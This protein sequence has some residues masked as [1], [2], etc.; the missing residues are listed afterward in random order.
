MSIRT[1]VDKNACGLLNTSLIDKKNL[2][3]A[4]L[5][6]SHPAAVRSLEY[7]SGV[8]CWNDELKQHAHILLDSCTVPY[9]QSARS[10]LVV[11]DTKCYIDTQFFVDRAEVSEILEH[12]SQ[13][14]DPDRP[15]AFGNI[16]PEGHE[17]FAFV[18][19][20]KHPTSRKLSQSGSTQSS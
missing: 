8:Y 19:I 18:V 20:P 13:N 6:S 7:A 3:A 15:W 17:F 11:D 1:I 12:E 9:L 10:G 5:V 2:F 4:G 16:L 14:V